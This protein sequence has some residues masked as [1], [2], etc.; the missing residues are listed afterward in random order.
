MEI[1][2]RISKSIVDK[3]DKPMIPVTVTHCGEVGDNKSFFVND[4]FSKA[5]LERIRS[6]N[7][8]NINS[9][10]EKS[11]EQGGEQEEEAIEYTP[12]AQIEAK[13]TRFKKDLIDEDTVE[14][15]Q[16]K[17]LGKRAALPEDKKKKLLDLKLKMNEARK[18]NLAAVY[19]E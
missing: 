18:K 14:I 1:V 10:E 13:M 8:K 15:N 17:L 7:E 9:F 6:A 12:E 19:E 16:D 11:K 2:R 3:K 5:G 4:P